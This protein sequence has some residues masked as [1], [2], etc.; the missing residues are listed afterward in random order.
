MCAACWRRCIEIGG[1]RLFSADGLHWA[2][3]TSPQCYLTSKDDSANSVVWHNG[4]Y[5]VFN[6]KDELDPAQSRTCMQYSIDGILDLG[7]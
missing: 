7:F 6:R 2:P 5:L 3:P 4:S 1:F